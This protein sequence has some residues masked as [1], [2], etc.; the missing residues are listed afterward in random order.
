MNASGDNVAWECSSPK[1]S[2][3][4]SVKNIAASQIL[5]TVKTALYEWD[6][7]T[8]KIR[9]SANVE[10]ILPFQN[11]ALPT[12]G[13][14][15]EALCQAGSHATRRE[16]IL[17]QESG[18]NGDENIFHT[19]YQLFLD[20]HNPSNALILEDVGC[21]WPDKEGRP[22]RA[23]G[24]VRVVTASEAQAARRNDG[25]AG[26]NNRREFMQ[27]LENAVAASLETDENQGAFFI[28]SIDGLGLVN[29][30][31][32]LPIA[33]KLIAKIAERLRV[34]AGADNTFG[35]L[36][37]NKFGLIARNCVESEIEQTAHRFISSVFDQ[38][39]NIEGH[40][41][42]PSISIGA[43]SIPKHAKTAEFAFSRAREAL[44]QIRGKGYGRYAA[45][46]PENDEFIARR[47]TVKMANEA[48]QALSQ[49]R[50]EQV[51]QPV[52]RSEDGEPV[53][54]EALMRLRR[55]NGDLLSASKIIPA[56]KTLG[57]LALLD[58]KAISQALTKLRQHSSI[59]IAVN[60]SPSVL[61]NRSWTTTLLN[62]LEEAGEPATRLIVEITENTIIEDSS[63]LQA[64]LTE[65]R[66]LG[67]KVA[68]DDF[69]AG[70]TSFSTLRGLKLDYLKID[71][72]F[73]QRAG[74]SEVD[75]IFLKS[76]V[77]I[78]N[79]RKIKT[80]AEWV[81][82]EPTAALM[83]T[84]GIHAMQGYYFAKPSAD[85][86]NGL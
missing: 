16:A 73:V 62:T 26:Q 49:D 3:E 7:E 42:A 19:I 38:P 8:D 41:I 37:A 69:G 86:L 31:Y 47:K 50:I 80:I 12:S 54:F 27:S 60:L 64:I 79:A 23:C 13:Q 82:D 63:A 58:Q 65:L 75:Y 55:I 56:A 4:V 20:Q 71:G 29:E 74:S 30:V 36:S 15:Y 48:F 76:L 68:L 5:T 78:A 81:E 61:L 44:K 35:K 66:I 6:L 1:D 40:L 22:I 21:W 52:V 34:A 51:Y 32:G 11:S 72:Q 25:D 24:T 17:K 14:S 83:R 46:H 57:L 33:D 67:V 85:C 10:H 84:L 2:L 28:A 77:D 9:W 39:V 53:F 59:F 43:V 70:Y 45:W 18:K